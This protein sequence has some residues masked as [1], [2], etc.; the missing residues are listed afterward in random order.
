MYTIAED[1]V[2]ASLLFTGT[3]FGL[4]TSIDGGAHWVQ[5]KAGLPTIAIRDLE[6][7][8]VLQ[9]IRMV[10]VDDHA[11]AIVG[12]GD[13]VLVSISPTFY[14]QLLCTSLYFFANFLLYKN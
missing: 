3:E 9:L 2:N 6:I 8:L 13:E 11:V 10:E 1:H 12:V 5:L 14:K 7:Q 4:F